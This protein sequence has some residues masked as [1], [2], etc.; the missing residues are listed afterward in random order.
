MAAGDPIK[1]GSLATG[2]IFLMSAETGVII[3]SYDRDV[4][5]KKLE[6]YDASVGYT[7]GVIY[8]DFKAIYS[9]KGK[10]SGATGLAAASVGVALTIANPSTGYGVGAGGIYTDS[11]KVSHQGEQLRELTISATQHH[12]IA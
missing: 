10:I 1:L 2:V 3:E 5:A 8:H 12:S 4:D 9:L 7:T 6:Q 11:A